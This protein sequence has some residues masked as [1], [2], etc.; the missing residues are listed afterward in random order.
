MKFETTQDILPFVRKPGSYLGNEVN[1]FAKAPDSPGSVDLRVALC[2]PD[3]YEIGTSHFGM[4][5]L[6]HILN[7][8][9]GIAAER[10]FSPGLDLEAQLRET[11]LPMVSLETHTPLNEFDILGMSLL[12][13]LNYTNVLTLLDLSGIPF[14]AADRDASHPLV[15]AGGPCT[16]NPEPV[17][18][19]F[20]ALVVGD[21]ETVVQE[22]SRIWRE[23]K[24]RGEHKDRQAVLRAWSGVHGVYVPGF[25]E[26]SYDANGFQRV[27]PRH[28]DYTSVTRAIEPALRTEDFPK[29]PVVPFG[30]P[31][32]D[33]LRLEIARGC[34]RGCR[35]CQ[36]GIIY[37]PVRER[38]VDDVMAIAETALAATGYDDI[39]FLSL[40]TGDYSCLNTLMERFLGVYRSRN[41]AVS[42]PS[43]RA[44]SL[45]EKDMTLIQQVRKTG[46]TIAPEAGTQR[47]RDVINKNI[48][49]EAIADTVA[50]AFRLGWRLIKFYFMVGLP[51]ET[52][53]DVDGI[54][55]LVRRLAKT[56]GAGGKKNS[57]NVSVA[58]FIPKAHT[59]FQWEPQISREQARERLF[60]LKDRLETRKIGFKW[61][62]PDAGLLEGVFA[63]GDRRLA[64]L[65]E[66]AYHKG[67]RFDGWSDC[68]DFSKWQAAA[69]DCG[70]DFDF[71]TTRRRDVNEPLPW[72]HI[73]AGISR[74]FLL[75]EREKA[76]EG[77]L[78]GDC[79][80][81]ECQ[82][83]GVCDF[84]EIKPVLAEDRPV[85]SREADTAATATSS[86][87][88]AP[89]T[90]EIEYTK[91]GPARFFGHLE[92][93]QIITR[94]VHRAG[95]PVKFSEGFHPKPKIAFSDP[96]PVGFESERELM[97]LTLERPERPDTVAASLNAA[98]PEGI[99][100]RGAGLAPK[101]SKR[102]PSAERAVYSL[103]S[104]IPVF[105]ASQLEAF[106]AS[107]RQ[108]LRL[109]GKKGKEKEID[110]SAVLARI[111]VQDAC[112]LL[113][114]IKAL[115]GQ[116]VRPDQVAG[117]V[118]GLD[119]MAL[120]PF[121]VVKRR[122]FSEHL[123]G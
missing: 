64:R 86:S 34:S 2:F 60:N 63:R 120:K 5:I 84:D 74:D 33:R 40:S 121:R 95:I 87:G 85:E 47:L 109:P 97:W 61:Q 54:V 90:L 83:C 107:D 28:D 44:G 56:V 99:A 113:M 8:D 12:Y 26:V 11:G 45:S 20:D 53:K 67:C 98:L 51:T 72:N 76:L 25:F 43:F 119:S 69:D 73:S 81:G 78:T 14:Y 9:P 100:I 91:T 92:F 41:I 57:I 18:D 66:T 49:E 114:E 39:S 58:A 96:L 46:F 102:T 94:A 89:V 23:F 27:T 36:A 7:K 103:V 30:R 115:P 21:G 106:R 62:N 24:T 31:V 118:F 10:V 17:A 122:F 65:I 80:D 110:L 22:M 111:V 88:E 68:F 75:G 93:V 59:P 37:R 52:D 3:V 104:K 116:G 42:I 50:D 16:F 70:I 4:Q 123:E 1:T 38:G 35:F 32:H 48:S 82:G 6:Y 79:R 101:K 117:F 77:N 71:Y 55:S 105:D 108:V 13:E 19:F 112:H 15:I 29:T